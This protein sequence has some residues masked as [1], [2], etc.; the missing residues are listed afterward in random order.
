MPAINKEDFSVN[1]AGL[2]LQHAIGN[3]AGTCRSP[4]D[5]QELANSCVSAIMVGSITVEP[6]EGNKGNV[7]WT[8]PDGQFSLNS[9]G[10]PNKGAEF[11]KQELQQE[12]PKMVE[13]AHKAGK[14]LFVSVAGF[15]PRGY[16]F[17]AKLAFEARADMV[18]LNL[19]C[20]NVYFNDK[21]KRIPC[22]NVSETKDILCEVETEVGI[23]A[24][25]A[26]KLNPISDP[27][28]LQSIA[29]VLEDWEL[30]KT[31]TSCNTFPNGL[32]LDEKGKPVIT[33]GEGFGGIS[34]PALKPF[35]LG[36][37][38]QLR[39]LLPERI[40]II[41]C[42]GI[43]TGRDVADFLVAG[44]KAV[45]VGTAFLNGGVTVFDNILREYV[46]IVLDRQE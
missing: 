29:W 23:E 33:F 26:I 15:S 6:R 32:A 43:S 5:I 20:P 38:K 7:F 31:V 1:L 27:F 10:L 36:Q 46:S 45:Q 19:S 2:E 11:Y 13:I 17:L 30:V 42:G 8:S 21:Q 16:A 41:G 24:N 35:A 28:L 4:E 39:A 14:P 3:A 9:N 37:V 12:L 44:A 34:G 22:F 40:D 25:I 18:E